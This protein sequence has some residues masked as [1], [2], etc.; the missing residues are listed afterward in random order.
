MNALNITCLS[1]NPAEVKSSV[2]KYSAESPVLAVCEK[3]IRLFGLS[4]GKS[5]VFLV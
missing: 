5:N 3:L 1:L 4:R 2:G